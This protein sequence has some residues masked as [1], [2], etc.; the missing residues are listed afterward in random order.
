MSPAAGL[1]PAAALFHGFSD[2]TRLAIL[3]HLATGEHKVREL[4]ADA[5]AAPDG[6]P[7][8]SSGDPDGGA[9]VLPEGVDPETGE[10]L[11]AAA[12]PGR[13]PRRQP[14]TA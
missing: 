6:D 8:E 3:R 11:G 1:G 7:S 4:T 5:P 13:R 14:A 2:P 12:G 10:L 9:P